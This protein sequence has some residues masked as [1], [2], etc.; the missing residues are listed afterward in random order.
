MGRNKDR[1]KN[2]SQSSFSSEDEEEDK[3]DRDWKR[4]RAAKKK[5]KSSRHSSSRKEKHK[6]HK[7]KRKKNQRK[8][9]SS[10]SDLL[11]INEHGKVF[12]DGKSVVIGT[13]L[14]LL[15]NGVEFFGNNK[16]LHLDF[17]DGFEND[18][19]CQKFI[20]TIEA[21]EKS[22]A[23]QL[24]GNY[25]SAFKDVGGQFRMRTRLYMKDQEVLST[26]FREGEEVGAYELKPGEIGYFQLMISHVWT[27]T[28]N[29][30]DRAGAIWV[31]TDAELEQY[32]SKNA[33]ESVDS[34]EIRERWDFEKKE[35]KR[36]AAGRKER[37]ARR[38]EKEARRKEREKRREIL[39]KA[40]PKTNL[41]KLSKYGR[42]RR[43]E[44]EQRPPPNPRKHTEKDYKKSTSQN[45][46][47]HSRKRKH[48]KHSDSHHNSRDHTD[49]K[50]SRPSKMRE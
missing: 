37:A 27:M 9:K 33:N 47:E 39:R 16:V 22:L 30:E 6:S 35:A 50:R 36:R 38:E 13:P 44:L 29:G 5:V 8:E 20:K 43:Q 10:T 26:F 12:L 25:I 48:H 32:D 18:A 14:M 42:K 45:N 41:N 24:D 15:P 7:H 19:A 40:P 46:H 11:S 28:T 49:R 17:P 1:I 2:D 4:K 23:S 31:V 21:Y 3:R 34:D